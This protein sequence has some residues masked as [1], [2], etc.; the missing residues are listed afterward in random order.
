MGLNAALM[1][2]LPLSAA[3]VHKLIPMACDLVAAVLTYRIARK[4]NASANQAGILMLLMAFNP[5]I[6]LNSAGWCQIDS[7][8]SLLLMLVAYFA[9]C[10]NWM[11]VMPIYMLAVLVKPQALML[12]FLGLAAIVM[13]L[14]RDRKCWKPMLIGVGLALVTA[15]YIQ[16]RPAV[17]REPRRHLVAD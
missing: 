11:A 5:A 13:A 8:L 1:R 15:A 6:F 14:I 12:G 3:A 16:H 2:V 7:V 9:V 17:Q 10:G 4:K